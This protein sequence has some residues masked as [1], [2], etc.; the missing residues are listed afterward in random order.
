MTS[1]PSRYGI[2]HAVSD[3]SRLARMIMVVLALAVLF[4]AAAIPAALAAEKT[5]VYYFWGDG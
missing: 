1:T 4:G 3:P 5:T 2:I